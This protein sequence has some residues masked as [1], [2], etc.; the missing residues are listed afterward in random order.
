ME[1]TQNKQTFDS[2]KD[3]F[4][5]ESFDYHPHKRGWVWITIF[6][7]IFFGSGF[8]MLFQGG[9]WGDK[10]AA[11]T[12][13]LALAMYFF[14]HRNGEQHHT[15][16]VTERAIFIDQ[17]LIPLEQFRG[18]WFVYDQ[19]AA[20]IHLQFKNKRRDHKITL[21]MGNRVPEFFRQNFLKVKLE[22]LEGKKESS[23]DLW[24]RALK[25]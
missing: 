21:Q 4:S 24:I 5:W 6:C 11:V 14:V 1:T 19:T 22:E 23:L 15:V 25:L 20:L 3:I 9:G 7:C 18:Y 17:K 16:R 10:L 8:L 2:G 13:L 12:F